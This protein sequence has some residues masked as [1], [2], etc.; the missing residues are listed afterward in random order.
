M[1][2][3]TIKNSQGSLGKNIGSEEGPQKIL[4]YLG[5]HG[6]DIPID[7]HNL[8]KTHENVQASLKTFTGILL[9][10]DHSFTYSAVKAFMK[11]HPTGKFIVF[12]A[13]P[14]CVNNF[15]PPS[16]EDYLRVL[17][18]EEII[19]AEQVTLIGTRAIDESEEIFLKVYSVHHFP[20]ESLHDDSL[21]LKH[22]KKIN[23][24]Y[25]VSIDIDVL[26]PAYAPGTG[27][28]EE[29]GLTVKQLKKYLLMLRKATVIDLMEVNPRKDVKDVT[30]K[31]AAELLNVFL[32]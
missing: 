19:S 30:S 14:D 17:L 5:M 2:I 23:A 28:P 4:E 6:N 13:H 11:E 21:L 26:D 24:P 8:E 22:L 10:G 9:G 15:Y 16:H 20:I 29:N 32:A 18:E 25:Y 1:K 31:T 7:E 12:D 3:L 27:Y